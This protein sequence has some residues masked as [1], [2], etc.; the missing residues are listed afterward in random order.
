MQQSVGRRQGTKEALSERAHMLYHHG[1]SSKDDLCPIYPF[2]REPLSSWPATFRC[3]PAYLT[4]ITFKD[5]LAWTLLA[6]SPFL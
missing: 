6:S 5:W 1:K 3:A 2:V 4:W